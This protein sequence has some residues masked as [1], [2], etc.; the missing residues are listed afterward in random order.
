MHADR[1]IDTVDIR[2]RARRIAVLQ[3]RAG[4]RIMHA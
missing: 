2:D 1:L 3:S 4:D